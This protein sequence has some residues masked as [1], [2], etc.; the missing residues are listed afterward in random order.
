MASLQQRLLDLVTVIKT[1]TKALRTMI[2]GANNGNVTGLQTTATNLV[3]AINEVKATADAASGAAGASINDA[4][5]SSLTVY[6]SNKT[7][8]EIN[9]AKAAVKDEILGG[10]GPTV[11][12]LLEIAN[13][14][15]TNTTTDAALVA[16]VALKAN[17]SDVYTQAQLGDPDTNLVTIWNNA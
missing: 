2:S 1:E 16:T 15:Q 7:M 17:S 8:L 13:Q 11:D 14:L 3:G 5:L 12:T 6:S 10:A 9:A 4:A